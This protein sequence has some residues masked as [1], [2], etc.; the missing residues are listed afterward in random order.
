MKNT[1]S[2]SSSRCLIA[3]FGFL[4]PSPRIFHL[5]RK[6]HQRNPKLI[7][8]NT[9]TIIMKQVSKISEEETNSE[10]Q[11]QSTEEEVVQVER[12]RETRKLRQ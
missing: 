12:E 9:R 11:E 6:T 8:D 7:H 3:F 1:C 4:L 10:G 2:L 5:H